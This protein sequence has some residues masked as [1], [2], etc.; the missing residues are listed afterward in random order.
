MAMRI[1]SDMDQLW[2]I[3]FVLSNSNVIYFRINTPRKQG[4]LGQMNI[5]L[6]ADKTFTIAKKYGVYKEDEG[7]TFR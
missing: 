4:G 5:P 3:I 6:L 7:V 2:S 1:V